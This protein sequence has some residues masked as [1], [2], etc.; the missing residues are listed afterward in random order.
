MKKNLI[1]KGEV[2]PGTEA[3]THNNLF[4][5]N[6]ELFVGMDVHKA[7]WVVTVRSYDLELKTF[8]MQPIAE[9]LEKFLLSTYPNAKY[10]IVYDPPRRTALA[11]SGYTITF[12]KRVTQ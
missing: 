6:K 4:F 2:I 12:L 3:V 5:E 11:V 10:N 1:P 8:S 7:K 9:V